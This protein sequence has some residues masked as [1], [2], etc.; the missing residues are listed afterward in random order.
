MGEENTVVQ[1]LK[2]LAVQGKIQKLAKGKFYKARKTELGLSRPPARQVVKDLLE[3]DGK[4][5]GYLTGYSI[6]NS[7]Y[8]STQI[9][10][11]LQ[12]G[13]NKY[14]RAIKRGLYKIEFI[15]QPNTISKN[16][17]EL[18]QILDS[19]R[20]IAQI[21]ATTPNEACL[22][23]LQIFRELSPEKQKRLVRLSLKYTDYV[24]ALC[25]AMLEQIGADKE[26]LDKLK[27]SLRGITTYKIP[28]S[29][30]VL[31]TKSEWRIVCANRN[32]YLCQSLSVH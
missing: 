11:T 15:V 10:N 24:R 32:Q 29:E 18:L 12:I 4:P 7:L 17:I 23:F 5:I 27:K 6:Y 13:V 30:K 3:K 25:G 26:V 2:R 1:T 22:R 14:R 16:N 20:F 8:L 21:P 31:T 9:A 28:V 19:V